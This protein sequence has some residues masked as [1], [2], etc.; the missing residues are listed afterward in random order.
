LQTTYDWLNDSF[1]RPEKSERMCIHIL[2]D[3]TG[4]QIGSWRGAF[5]QWLQQRY[6]LTAIR[7]S[8]DYSTYI[9]TCAWAAALRRA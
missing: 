7:P 6:D 8:Y 5:R 3:F 2:Y 4:R 1:C 9:T